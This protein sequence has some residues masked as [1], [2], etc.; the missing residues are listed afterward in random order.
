M[1]DPVAMYMSDLYTVGFSLGKLP[2]M[3]LP[4][5]CPTG[6]QITGAYGADNEVIKF[7]YNLDKLLKDT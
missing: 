3:S 2:T 5:G 6:L 1:Q 7:A 4:G